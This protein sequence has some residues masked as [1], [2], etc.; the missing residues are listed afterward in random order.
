M[1][2]LTLT[3]RRLIQAASAGAALHVFGG[4]AFAQSARGAVQGEIRPLSVGYL[5]DSDLLPSLSPQPWRRRAA[6]EEGLRVV[7]AERMPIGD[8]SLAHGTVEMRVHGFYPG[9]PPRRLANFSAVVLTVFFPSFDPIEPGPFPYYSW[10]GKHWP[11]PSKS[12]PNRFLVPLRDD[13]GLELVVEVFDSRPTG[14]GQRVGQGA[15]RV[16]RGGSRQASMGRPIGQTSLYTDF[17]VDW[18][19]GRPKL[20]RGFYLLGL[21]PDAWRAPARLENPGAKSEVLERTSLV[22]SFEGVPEDDPR[23]VAA[24]T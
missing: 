6:V 9:I 7:P 3:R 2:G 19:A 16:L 4:A 1:N 10:Q 22:V 23:L 14:P 15:A 20:Q 21:S 18:N 5:E 12:P 17:T 13:G 11:G 24:A 8:Q